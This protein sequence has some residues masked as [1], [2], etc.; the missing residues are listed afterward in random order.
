MI[1]TTPMSPKIL[2]D[3]I[4]KY[5][6]SDVYESDWTTDLEATTST[7]KSG[8]ASSQGEE[9]ALA[10]PAE[11]KL[12]TSFAELMNMAKLNMMHAAKMTV[13]IAEKKAST[14]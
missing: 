12:S 1:G 5:N 3:D 11:P 2:S 14:T 9:G 6:I 10:S 4:E 7:E 8:A 13:N